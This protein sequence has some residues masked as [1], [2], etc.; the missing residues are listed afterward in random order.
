MHSKIIDNSTKYYQKLSVLVIC[1]LKIH[2]LCFINYY[3]TWC[4]ITNWGIILDFIFDIGKCNDCMKVATASIALVVCFPSLL[5]LKYLN[6][7]VV[8]HWKSKKYFRNCKK[9]W[10][11][12]LFFWFYVQ[13]V[14]ILILYILFQ[15][16][17]KPTNDL[18]RFFLPSFLKVEIST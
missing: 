2:L 16:T 9:I 6:F 15:I 1:K 10:F 17:W 7:Y 4:F 3:L 11:D 18:P 8:F 5:S 14:K 13:L 12:Y